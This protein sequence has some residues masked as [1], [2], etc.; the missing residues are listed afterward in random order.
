M[1]R[2]RTAYPVGVPI[3]HTADQQ[4]LDRDRDGYACG[5]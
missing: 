3:G 4:K 1:N 5:R 2:I